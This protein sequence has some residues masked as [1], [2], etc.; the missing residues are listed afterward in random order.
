L[1]PLLAASPIII[2]TGLILIARQSALRAGIA[3]LI[4]TLVIGF[5]ATTSPLDISSCLDALWQAIAIT[6]PI[7]YILLGG[8]FLYAVLRTGGAL[9][10]IAEMTVAAA[11]SPGLRILLLIYGLGIFF[12]SA[13]GFG[14]GLIVTVPLFLSLGYSP[15]RAGLLALL[16]QCAV[17][18]GALAIG[19]ALG[20]K[21]AELPLS[22]ASLY[23]LLFSLPSIILCGAAALIIAQIKQSLWHS[24]LQVLGFASVLSAS[25]VLCSLAGAA[26]LAGCAG[27]LSVI[28]LVLLLSRWTNKKPQPAAESKHPVQQRSRRFLIPLFVLI[29]SLALTRLVPPL[30]EFFKQFS[31]HSTDNV[32]AIAPLYH[33]GFWLLFASV[34]G[35]LVFRFS[36][37]QLL[38]ISRSALSQWLKAVLAI[39]GFIASG[40][41]MAAAG[42]TE[43]LTQSAAQATIGAL[44]MLIPAVGALGGFLTASNAGSNAIFMEFQIQLTALAQ[45]DLNYTAAAQNAAASIACMMS[46]GRLALAQLLLGQTVREYEL[47]RGIMPVTLLCIA[48][49]MG[50]LFCLTFFNY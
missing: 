14:V 8:V 45:F 5:L 23:A 29:L 2:A 12:E 32:F 11:P 36:G 39:T 37:S 26:E 6:A 18:W 24:L 44:P 22:S 38:Q 13:T 25:I 43:A 48:S 30:G 7:A 40:Q 15:L 41:V 42:M 10:A 27:G 47:L 50:L 20:A 16:G 3:L 1:N 49:M 28:M 33:A 46:P 4:M 21:L 19:M 9:E 34:S 31:I 17:P 35:V